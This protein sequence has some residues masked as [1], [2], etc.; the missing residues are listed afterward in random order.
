[1]WKSWNGYRGSN[2]G[3]GNPGKGKE[4]FSLLGEYSPELIESV[5]KGVSNEDLY[6]LVKEIPARPLALSGCPHRGILHPEEKR[7]VVTGDIGCY[8][9][10]L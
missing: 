8:T 4:L 9:L 7:L 2:K 10:G 5:L 6:G 3:L 1:V